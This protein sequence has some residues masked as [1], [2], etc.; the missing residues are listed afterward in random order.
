MS[1]HFYIDCQRNGKTFALVYYY[2]HSETIFAI[3]QTQG[4]IDYIYNHYENDYRL[5][6][7]RFI[8]CFG[9][10][11]GSGA[12]NKKYTH[13]LF[14][15]KKFSSGSHDCGL[16]ILE[17]SLIDTLKSQDSYAVAKHVII[18]FDNDKIK[19]DVFTYWNNM[20]TF[21]NDPLS[22][23]LC[24][25]NPYYTA[26]CYNEPIDIVPF[27]KL[28]IVEDLLINQSFV[29]DKSKAVFAKIE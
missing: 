14:P 29:L 25:D 28:N 5:N 26:N 22:E 7:I 17:P 9:G 8:E 1:G 27:E 10:Y 24:I 12:D 6:I 11:V 21:L 2:G 18:D 4:L 3:H 16:V 23:S 15:D 20:A 13:N 19:W